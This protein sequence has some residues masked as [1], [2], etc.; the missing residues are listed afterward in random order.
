M[1]LQ[2]KIKGYKMNINSHTPSFCS[3]Y[4]ISG[5]TQDVKKFKEKLDYHFDA[6]PYFSKWM[7]TDGKEPIYA[8][9]PLTEHYY[10]SQP[11]YQELILTNEHCLAFNKAI[12]QQ[13][14]REELQKLDTNSDLYKELDLSVTDL[15]KSLKRIKENHEAN[16]DNLKKMPIKQATKIL[17]NSAKAKA[18]EILGINAKRIMPVDA[19]E[20]L[21]AIENNRFD[22]IHGF[23]KN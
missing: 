6:N 17:K 20:A 8:T 14:L 13:I 19:K 15:L 18:I 7:N 10:N 16:A 5:S 23:I 22:F 9:I 3:R 11:F 21:N 2:E 4:I 1:L 12:N